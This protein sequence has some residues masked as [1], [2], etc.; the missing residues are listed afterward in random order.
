MNLEIARSQEIAKACAHIEGLRF[1]TYYDDLSGSR[2]ITMDWLSGQ[3]I[4]EFL[5]TNPSQEVRDRIGQSLWEF[6]HHQIHVLK[7]VHADPHPGNF[8]MEADGTLGVIDFGCVKVIPEDFYEAYFKLMS[9][10]LVADDEEL[11]PI[12]YRLNFLY[13]DDTEQ[14]KAVYIKIFKDMDESI[15][16]SIPSR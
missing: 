7:K 14:E 12:L 2:I 13:A 3:H 6:Y 4:K 15:G 1:P 11:L 16:S 5:Q 9:K 8:L 10:D